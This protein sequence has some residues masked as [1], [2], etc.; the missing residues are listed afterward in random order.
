MVSSS[1]GV[2]MQSGVAVRCTVDRSHGSEVWAVAPLTDDE[3][4]ALESYSGG[5]RIYVGARF[6]PVDARREAE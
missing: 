3:S 1:Y 6:E 5:S 4:E 2:D